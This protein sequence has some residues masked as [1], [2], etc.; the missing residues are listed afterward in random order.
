[1]TVG[2]YEVQ[3]L[4]F[5]YFLFFGG[6]K[7]VLFILAFQFLTCLSTHWLKMW[8]FTNTQ[9]NKWPLRSYYIT[10]DFAGDP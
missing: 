6:K 7:D 4:A 5:F 8:L 3:K 9:V 1:M 10:V 2:Q